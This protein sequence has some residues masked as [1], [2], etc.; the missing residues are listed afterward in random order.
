MNS[1][2][3]PSRVRMEA[4]VLKQLVTEV[5]ETVASD[6][7]FSNRSKRRFGI[8]DMWKIQK[9]RKSASRISR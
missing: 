5:R 6:L 9:N 7:R 4:E 1:N 3:M 8:V 2:V